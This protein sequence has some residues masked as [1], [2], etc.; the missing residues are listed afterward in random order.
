MELAGFTAAEADEL[1]RAIGFTRSRERLDRMEARL[2]DGLERNG[3]S[4]AA[5]AAIRKSLSSFAL[6]GFPESHAISFALIAYASA[7]LRVHRTTAFYA[8]LINNQPMGFYSTASLVQDA[9]RHGV[10]VLPVC[11]LSSEGKCQVVDDTTIR[12]GFCRSRDC[13]LRR[14]R[15]CWRRG[16]SSRS[17]RCRTSCAARSF[18]R[19]NGACWR[20]REP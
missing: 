6:Y 5:S 20:W 15:G 14:S 12:L 11:V 16:G 2:A 7:W 1:R 18:P 4:P 3:V 17:H 10:R 19:R 8:G 9:R 13:G